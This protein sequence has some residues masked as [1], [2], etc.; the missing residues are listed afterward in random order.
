MNILLTLRNNLTTLV[1]PF[2]AFALIYHLLRRWLHEMGHYWTCHRYG[3]MCK[4]PKFN[5]FHPFKKGE[6]HLDD[7]EE[8]QL[9]KLLISQR[10]EI[11]IVGLINEVLLFLGCLII[12]SLIL[13]FSQNLLN[14]ILL[15]LCILFI[16]LVELC[17]FLMNSIPKKSDFRL[18]WT[19]Q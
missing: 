13:F 9:K 18:F 8:K 11:F 2:L 16:I 3:I 19:G 17:S 5:F 1:L 4:R 6:T 10:R 7:K 14:K 12:L 15:G